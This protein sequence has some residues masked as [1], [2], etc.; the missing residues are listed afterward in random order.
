M[1][2]ARALGDE[3]Q[4]QPE[5]DSRQRR[6]GAAAGAGAAAKLRAAGQHDPERRRPRCPTSCSAPGRSPAASPTTTGRRRPARRSVRPRPSCPSPAPRRTRPARRARPGRRRPP[7]AGSRSARPARRQQRP[8]RRPP[9]VRPAC[10]RRRP[11][12]AGSRRERVPPR[13]SALPQ[14]RLESRASRAATGQATG[15]RA[16][17]AGRTVDRPGRRPRRPYPLDMVARARLPTTAPEEFRRALAALRAARLGREIVLEETPAPQRLAPHAVALTADVDVAGDDG[18]SA[19]GRFVLLHDPAGHEAWQGTFRVVTFV[20][21]DLEPEMAADPLLPGVGWAWLIEALDGARRRRSPPRAARSPGSSSESF[22]AM[23]DR[24]RRRPRSR[25]AP[26]GPR[27]TSVRARTCWPGATCCARRPG[28]RRCRPAW[29]PCRPARRRQPTA[30]ERRRSGLLR[31][32]VSAGSRPMS[33]QDSANVHA[34]DREHPVTALVERRGRRVARAAAARGRRRF[35]ALVGRGQPVRARVPR[36]AALRAARAPSRSSRPAA[37]AEARRPRAAAP[38]PVTCASSTA[39]CPTAPASPCSRE[40]RAAGWTRGVVLP[41]PRTPTPCARAR[42]RRARLPGD[43][44][45]LRRHRRR[46]RRRC[47]ASAA[48]AAPG[49]T[50]AEALSA[51]EV[52]VLQLVA[53]GRPTRRSARRSAC[54]R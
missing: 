37:L 30:D 2:V 45:G 11:A 8:R 4:R 35:T 39:P 49:V 24:A 38:R 25:S 27:W 9:A 20:R 34:P 47:L 36:P 53:D 3:Q 17:R 26:P 51:R 48:P 14:R 31:L 13:K 16:R 52:E 18:S 6:R 22:G 42:R 41:P 43:R 12:S 1:L 50:G 7:R 5:A 23:A 44:V 32:Q 40:L 15:R 21:A 33:S 46:P 28:C 19:T 54:P 29:S 10:E